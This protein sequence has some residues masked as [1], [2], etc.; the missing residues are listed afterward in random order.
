MTRAQILAHAVDVLGL[1][2]PSTTQDRLLA[3]VDLIAKWNQVYNLTAVR[4]PEAMLTQHIVDSLAVLPHL[5]PGSLIDVGTGA[6]LPGVPVALAEPGRPV[7]VLDSV[8]KKTSFIKQVVI[9]LGLANITVVCA[10]AETHRP[11]GGYAVVISRAFAELATFVQIAGHLCAPDGVM[12]AMKGQHPRDELA[13][14]PPHYTA[15]RVIPLDVPGLAAERH[16]AFIRPASIPSIS[17]G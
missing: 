13:S 1:A 5:P 10:R 7:T 16:L 11:P 12:V 15:E 9:E 17:V 6:G 3:Y 4:D 14:L 8:S 2:L